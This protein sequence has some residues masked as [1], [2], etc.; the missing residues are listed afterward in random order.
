MKM[1]ETKIKIKIDENL[2]LSLI[3]KHS[4]DVNVCG[5]APYFE[6]AINAKDLLDEIHTVADCDKDIFIDYV[7]CLSAKDHISKNKYDRDEK[8]DVLF[9][10]IEFPGTF[11]V[12]GHEDLKNC[13]YIRHRSIN[14][15]IKLS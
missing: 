13:P 10:N 14:K 8:I 6:K 5:F 9:T 2:L 15:T 12:I 1:T 3:S 11:K 7:K 4:V